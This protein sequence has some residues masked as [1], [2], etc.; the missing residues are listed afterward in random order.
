VWRKGY[1]VWRLDLSEPAHAFLHD[2]ARGRPFGKAVAASAR[3][4]QGSAGDQLFRWLR[5]WVAEGMFE[6]VTLS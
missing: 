6:G 3:R 5:D 4:L 2:L 1:E